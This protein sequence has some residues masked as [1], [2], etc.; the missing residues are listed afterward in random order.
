MLQIFYLFLPT[1]FWIWMIW[2]CV[3]YDPQKN[4]WIWLLI[5]FNFPGAIIYFFVRRLPRLDF[6]VSKYIQ[7]RLRRKDL[8]SAEAAVLNIGNS[9][10]LVDLGDLRRELQLLDQAKDSYLQALDKEPDNLKALWGIV[11]LEYQ[12]EKFTDAKDYLAKLLNL[13]SDY[14]YGNAALL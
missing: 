1:C 14:A 3:A 7:R 9:H 12:Q 13:K 10:Q 11:Q 8:W 6:P 5:L 4:T 2:E